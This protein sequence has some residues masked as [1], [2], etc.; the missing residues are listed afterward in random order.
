MN[1]DGVVGTAVP[2]GKKVQKMVADVRVTA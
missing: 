2:V 1:K